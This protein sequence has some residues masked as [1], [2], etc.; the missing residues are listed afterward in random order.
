M[1]D[2]ELKLKIIR[3]VKNSYE[4]KKKPPSLR[5]I[6]KHFKGEKLNFV[7]FYELFPRGIPE[8][9]KLAGVP[10][11]KERMKKT[12]KATEASKAKE[13]QTTQQNIPH[14]LMLTE[15]QTK[16]LE[17]IAYIEGRKDPLLIIDEFL[18]R[19]QKYRKTFDLSLEKIKIVADF[20]GELV[21]RGWTKEVVVDYLVDLWNSGYSSLE[22][23]E[24]DE[25]LRFFKDLKK[26]KW[27]PMKFVSYATENHN[28]FTWYIEY[29]QGNISFKE[30]E[31]Q[32]I[33][34]VKS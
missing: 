15:K 18:D 4:Q 7:R 10:V 22:F 8:L 16:D 29:E 5:G 28:L 14:R 21:D 12:E 13:G 25:I 1:G 19:D 30:F 3:Y 9:F 20:L 32:M 6:I 26:R 34:N 2:K 24:G 31:K 27:D 17:T 23:P 11:P 33:Q